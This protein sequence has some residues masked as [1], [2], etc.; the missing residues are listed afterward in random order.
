MTRVTLRVKLKIDCIHDSTG[1]V[2]Q[3]ALS[4]DKSIAVGVGFGASMNFRYKVSVWLVQRMLNSFVLEA[5]RTI[6]ALRLCYYYNPS[7]E[8]HVG[9]TNSNLTKHSVEY[10]LGEI[11]HMNPS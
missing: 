8:V 10:S 4:S 9:S 3:T 1:G 2:H 6:S 11:V 5:V 7:E